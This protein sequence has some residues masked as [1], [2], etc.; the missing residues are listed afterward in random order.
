MNNASK[1]NAPKNFQAHL[2]ELAKANLLIEIDHPI[3]KDSELHPLVRWQFQGGIKEQDRKAFLF[4]NVVDSE[5]R[6]YKTPV[7][8]GAYAGSPAIY[9][10]GLGVPIEEIGNVWVR[11]ME[12]PIQPEPVQKGPCQEVILINK[13]LQKHGGGMA[14]LPVPISTP[15]FDA[16][17]YLTATLV[18]TKDPET[19]VQNM[20]TYRGML[21]AKDRLGVRMAARLGGAGG[22][23]H[24]LKYKKRELK[25]PVAI[26]VGCAPAILFTG[27]QKLPIDQDELAVAGGLIGEPVTT[28]NCKTVD[29]VVPADCEFVIEGEIATNYLEPEGP[30]G[31]S[32]GHLALE[33]FN[34]SMQITAIT[35]KKT[36]VFASIISQVTP[37]ESSVLKK[38]AY[39]PL[40]LSHLK[41]VLNIKGISGVVMH[42]PLTNIRKVI[43]LKFDRSAPQ[44][45]IWRGLHGAAN[46]QAQCGKVVIAVSEDIDPNNADAVFWSIA[47]RSN[48]NTD[49]S[50]TAYRSGGHGP[51]SGGVGSDGTLLID[52]TLKHDMPPLA[53]PGK[54]YMDRAREIWETLDLPSISPQAPWFGYELGDWDDKWTAFANK[55]VQGKWT[56]NAL[57]TFER[58]REGIKPETPTRNV[59]DARGEQ[60]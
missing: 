26:V 11:G 23:Q 34:M 37:S 43:F 16:A 58:R 27:P 53:L 19:G 30:F 1:Q 51:K 45:E 13:D 18:I 31:E 12:K 7:A 17:P 2:K 54:K 50:I 41:S 46:L 5:G 3:N 56:E 49:L 9:A 55:A 24:W 42:E 25:M 32:H 8:V 33:D 59:K 36:P 39:E 10:A 29:L 14:A 20:G 47:Y 52:A 22:Y 38:V 21:K 57:D 40:Y 4:N 35:Y 6:Q 15:G 28:I 48:I 44:T 60:D